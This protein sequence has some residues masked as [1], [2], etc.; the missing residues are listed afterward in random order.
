MC[1][2]KKHTMIIIELSSFSLGFIYKTRQIE[3]S[4]EFRSGEYGVQIPSTAAG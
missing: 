4:S 2:P 3:K 1:E